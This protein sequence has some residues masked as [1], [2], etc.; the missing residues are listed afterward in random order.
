[1]YRCGG[2]LVLKFFI[3]QVCVFF[4]LLGIS[5]VCLFLIYICR[6]LGRVHFRPQRSGC[7]YLL[8]YKCVAELRFY[9]ICVLFFA[10]VGLP[11]IDSMDMW[12]LIS[13]ANG[14]SPRTEFAASAVT[15][16]TT[17]WK[18]IDS[19]KT[20]RL[21]QAAS[22]QGSLWPNAS[23]PTK[24]VEST[25]LDCSLVNGAGGACTSMY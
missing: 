13:G 23:S 1:M 19:G 15:L 8:C 4:W 24:N 5:N 25:K 7:R 16:I 9:S 17:E 11:P 10:A 20:G 2:R 22:W 3:T 14:T 12:P 6:N 21:L 18:L